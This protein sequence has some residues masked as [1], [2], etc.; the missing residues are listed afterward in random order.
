MEKRKKVEDKLEEYEKS[1]K[2]EGDQN[3]SKRSKSF[4]ERYI[5]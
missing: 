1:K 5:D 2:M 4:L 3:I